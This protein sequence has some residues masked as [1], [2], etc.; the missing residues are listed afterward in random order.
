MRKNKLMKN[1]LTQ[2]RKLSKKLVQYSQEF[3]EG[4]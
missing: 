4:L 3:N 1:R 2:A